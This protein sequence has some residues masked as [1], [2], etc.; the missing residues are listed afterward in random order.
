MLQIYTRSQKFK[1]PSY[2]YQIQDYEAFFLIYFTIKD[3][4]IMQFQQNFNNYLTI[5]ENVLFIKE[6]LL[7]YNLINFKLEF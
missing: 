1:F 2:K 3:F 5:N 4:Y 7:N 6:I